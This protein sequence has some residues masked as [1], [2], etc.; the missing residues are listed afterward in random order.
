MLFVLGGLFGL[1][2]LWIYNKGKRT[3]GP[4]PDSNENPREGGTP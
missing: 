2:L 1:V 3:A 4:S